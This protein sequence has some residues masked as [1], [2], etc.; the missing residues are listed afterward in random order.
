MVYLAVVVDDDP[1][2]RCMYQ[3]ALA[4]LGFGVLEASNGAEVLKLLETNRPE[5]LILDLR[6]PQVSGEE[7]LDYVR[8]AAH[9][10]TLQIIVISAHTKDVPRRVLAAN[11]QYLQKPVL[12][13]TIRAIAQR[14]LAS[15]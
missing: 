5:L 2:A 7:V 1:S 11:E 12:P 10:E 4:P 6:L 9:L 3:Q 14:A 8:S 15:Q 13:K